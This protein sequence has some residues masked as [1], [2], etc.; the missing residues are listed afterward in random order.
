MKGWCVTL[1]PVVGQN[2]NWF[3]WEDWLLKLS[4]CDEKLNIWWLLKCNE[5]DRRNYRFS[6]KYLYPLEI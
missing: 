2:V 5:P 1:P 4:N 6:N 3:D